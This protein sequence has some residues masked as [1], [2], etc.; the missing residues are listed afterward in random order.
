MNHEDLL[1]V[2][3]RICVNNA[4]SRFPLYAAGSFVI[5][6]ADPGLYAQMKSLLLLT[7]F[8]AIQHSEWHPHI[9]WIK[10]QNANII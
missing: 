3:G 5:S 10:F 2:Q 1:S 6:K 4:L 8:F 7:H 9:P